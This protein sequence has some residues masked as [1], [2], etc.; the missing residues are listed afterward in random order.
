MVYYIYLTTDYKITVHSVPKN[1]YALRMLLFMLMGWDCVSELQ[2]PMGL[3][4]IPQMIRYGAPVEKLYWLG[5]TDEL[6][7]EPIPLLL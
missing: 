2:P 3:L 6:R 4:S 7:E 1:V 5:K